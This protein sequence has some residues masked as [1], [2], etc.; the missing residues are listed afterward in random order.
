[1]NW[2]NSL[3]SLICISTL[4]NPFFQPAY[5]TG[6][7]R[8]GFIDTGISTKHID[9]LQVDQGKNYIFPLQDTEDRDGHGTA[10]A[11]MVL[12]SSRLG[13]EGSCPSAVAVPLVIHDRYPSGVAKVGDISLM[14]QA[15]YDAVDVFGCRVINI[16]MGVRS[17]TEDL[18]LA[19]DYAEENGVVV[20]S[21]VGN[22]NLLDP[23]QT[24]YPANYKRVVGV[25]AADDS[26][27]TYR[28]ADFSHRKG[29]SVLAQGSGVK[30]VTNRNGT[31]PMIRSGTS[32]S[33][34]YVAGLCGQLLIDTPSLTPGQVRALLYT[35]SQD[36][37]MPGLDIESGWGLVGIGGPNSELVTRSILAM[38]LYVYDGEVEAEGS[39]FAKDP[40]DTYYETAL[41]WT[42]EKGL[43]HGYG[44]GEFQPDNK[45]RREEL[46]T[47]LYRYAQY[48]AYDFPLVE[49]K[50]ILA[51]N[52]F[53][54]VSQYALAPMEWAW[55]TG[56]IQASDG[57]LMP[58]GQI[59]KDQLA[60]I[61]L[62]FSQL[63]AL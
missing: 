49:D 25:G 56:L 26:L 38:L 39:G 14:C 16:S 8:I 20:V 12:G 23:N 61:L 1:M 6:P 21:A 43:V 36:L 3:L 54:R 18:R 45:I 58:Q 7:V 19:V 60:T 9:R 41:A 13:L 37:A 24:Y 4:I 22:D 44:N 52:D 46:V 29:V 59:S 34:A 63:V 55:A 33:S 42:T 40:P 35:S 11:G 32:Y 27:D 51:C 30:T 10:T 50:T 2:K 17:E 15:I 48:K 53:D 62:S 28:V 31:D 57:Y 5:A 47:I